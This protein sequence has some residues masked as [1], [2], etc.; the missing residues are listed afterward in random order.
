MAR[1]RAKELFPLE[2][3][4]INMSPMIDMVFLLLIFFMA[5][6]TMITFQHD[7]R[8][9]VPVAADSRVPE[10]IASRVIINVYADGRISDEYGQLN[11]RVEDVRTMLAA[12][13]ERDAATRLHLRADRR[14]AHEK[15]KE[16]ITASADAGVNEIIIASFVSDK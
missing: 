9:K 15:V 13:R 8:V 16:I 1:R 2:E 5:G 10:L 7:R 11:L 4:E 12:A 6:S 14:V 3:L